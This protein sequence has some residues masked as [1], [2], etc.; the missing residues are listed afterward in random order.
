MTQW[1]T[2]F[3]PDPNP[4]RGRFEGRFPSSLEV[5]AVKKLSGYEDV[6]GTVLLVEAIARIER[7]GMMTDLYAPFGRK[8][9]VS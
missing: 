8:G 2:F 9:N 3:L 7:G 5:K 1:A 4:R 6:T